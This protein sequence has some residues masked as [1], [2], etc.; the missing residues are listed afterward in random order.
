MSF[1][2][3]LFASFAI[4]ALL[5]IGFVGANRSQANEQWLDDLMLQLAV[6]EACDVVEL[7]R[8]TEGFLGNNVFI[9][10][11]VQCEDGR[12]FDASRLEPALEFTLKICEVVET[13]C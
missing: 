5:N 10:A 3:N 9:D 8:S 4:T 11:R 1:A 6:D 2:R 13:E 12:Q 7:L